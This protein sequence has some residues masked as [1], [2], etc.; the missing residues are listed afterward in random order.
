MFIMMN[1]QAVHTVDELLKNFSIDD[2]IYCYYTGELEIFLT[3]LQEHEKASALKNIPNNALLLL[4]L[5]NIFGIEPEL[6]EE[7]I[8]NSF[9]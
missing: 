5:Y 1:G 4:R 8:R 2:L 3:E 7:E 9:S 6:T